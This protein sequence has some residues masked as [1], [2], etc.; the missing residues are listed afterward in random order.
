MRRKSGYVVARV[1]VPYC[2]G[3]VCFSRQEV[4]KMDGNT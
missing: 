1:K 4:R 3:L 2:A